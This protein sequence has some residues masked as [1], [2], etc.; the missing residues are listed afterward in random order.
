MHDIAVAAFADPE[1]A[2]PMESAAARF[3]ASLAEVTARDMLDRACRRLL[4]AQVDPL[5][6]AVAVA[7]EECADVA[8]AP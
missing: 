7:G 8:M 4:H 2:A 6:H 1:V 5:A 3:D